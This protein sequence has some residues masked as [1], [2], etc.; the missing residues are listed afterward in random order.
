MHARARSHRWVNE[1][2]MGNV[3]ELEL[4]VSTA[5][6]GTKRGARVH[7]CMDADLPNE[8]VGPE[9]ESLSMK[10]RVWL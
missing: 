2:V 5:P 3:S 4:D 1:R 7:I 8:R 9:Y 10:P 6:S